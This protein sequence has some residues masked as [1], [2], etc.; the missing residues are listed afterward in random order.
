MT[1]QMTKRAFKR[2]LCS[3]A[4][5]LLVV[6]MILYTLYHCVAA[7]SDRVVTDVIVPGVGKTVVSGEA[8]LFRDETVLSVSG[9]NYLCSYAW[10]NGAKV[11]ATSTLAQL[12]LTSADADTVRQYQETLIALDR[13]IAV[14]ESCPTAELLSSLASLRNDAQSTLI[15]TSGDSS[16]GAPMDQISDGAFSLLLLL[17]RIGALT[18]ENGGSGEALAAS[19]RAERQQLLLAASY[20]ART[21]MVADIAT[22]ATGGYFFYANQVDGYEQIFCRADLADMTLQE[23]DAAMASPRVTYGQGTTVVGK[24]VKSYSWSIAVPMDPSVAR[25]LEQ[26]EVYEVRFTDEYDLTLDMTLDRVIGSVAEGRAVAVFSCTVMPSGFSYTRYSNVEITLTKTQGL[27]V[28]ETALT[29]QGGVQGVYILDDGRVSFRAVQIEWQSDGY[30]LAYIPTKEERES[31]E[32]TTYHADRYIA[33]RDVV[34]IEGDDLY[35]G[36]YMD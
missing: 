5:R 4:F 31:E 12:Y 18:G 13:Q 25:E 24:L 36:K 16:D 14:A 34:I 2:L 9:G 3:V 22:D 32:N 15:T 1:L 6:A 30:I 21:L 7:F 8:V 33:V 29:Q 28:P 11:H 20:A 19:L 27:R 10:E 26:G 17:N 35:D 23:L